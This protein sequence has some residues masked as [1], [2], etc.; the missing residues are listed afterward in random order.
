[1][2]VCHVT[3]HLPP[4]QAANALL[5]AELGDWATA[6]G[7]HVTFV[8]QEPV[9]GRTDSVA[10]AGP[11]RHVSGRRSSSA[12]IR[13]LRIDTWQRAR[14]IAAALDEMASNADLIHLHSN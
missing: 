8:T 3:P 4:D 10:L 7:H 9:Q 13:A 2:R 6:A 5:P 11:V 12:L 14:A 1:M